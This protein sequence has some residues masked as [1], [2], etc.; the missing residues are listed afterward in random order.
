M[1]SL[2]M[3]YI[4]C[5][6]KRLAMSMRMSGVSA[7]RRGFWTMKVSEKMPARFFSSYGDSRETDTHPRRKPHT[8]PDE[9][10][11]VS[12]IPDNDVDSK[13]FEADAEWEEQQSAEARRIK[14]TKKLLGLD[15]DDKE[16]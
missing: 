10:Q 13:D 1:N 16:S 3:K 8:K 12:K 7:D 11:E 2:N 14:E 4:S 9:H 15:K 5:Y 6:A